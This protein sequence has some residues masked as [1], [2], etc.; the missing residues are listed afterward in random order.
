MDMTM[1]DVTGIRV[2]AGDEVEIFGSNIT[3]Q[4]LSSWCGTISYEILTGIS[5]RVKRI[6]IKQ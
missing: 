2:K 1:V 4:E 5:H 3:I 6:F